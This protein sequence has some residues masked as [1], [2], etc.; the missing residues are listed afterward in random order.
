MYQDKNL[1]MPFSTASAGSS[2][3]SWS[4]LLLC[5]AAPSLWDPD[6]TPHC[7]PLVTASCGQLRPD[8]ITRNV[9]VHQVESR[10]R[11]NHAVD[12]PSFCPLQTALRWLLLTRACPVKHPLLI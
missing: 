6:E 5:L 3:L 11:R 7:K 9:T 10:D 8:D 1:H 4:V 12:V 2:F